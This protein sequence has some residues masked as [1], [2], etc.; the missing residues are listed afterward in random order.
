V[1]SG[2]R[3]AEFD[4]LLARGIL[5]AVARPRAGVEPLPINPAALDVAT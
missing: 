3:G 4:Q 5:V 2:A 1:Q